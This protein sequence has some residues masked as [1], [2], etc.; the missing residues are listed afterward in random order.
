MFIWI[1]LRS[2]H[3]QLPRVLLL[4]QLSIFLELKQRELVREHLRYFLEYFGVDDQLLEGDTEPYKE[5]A[6]VELP[7]ELAQ[8]RLEVHLEAETHLVPV[9]H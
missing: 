6:H 9:C 7:K 2:S 5:V 3:D 1:D 4:V 8:L